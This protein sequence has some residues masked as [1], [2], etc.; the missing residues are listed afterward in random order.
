MQITAEWIWHK[1]TPCSELQVHYVK[2]SVNGWGFPGGSKCMSAL[3]TILF[4]LFLPLI[5]Q[6]IAQIVPYMPADTAPPPVVTPVCQAPPGGSCILAHIESPASYHPHPDP[7]GP[8]S[9]SGDRPHPSCRFELMM[10]IPRWGRCTC[11]S[12]SP[13]SHLFLWIQI[14]SAKAV[15]L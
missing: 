11:Q 2:K 4:F 10:P 13:S 6:H 5:K 14:L 3:S 9:I 1:H 15:L 8:D 12:R 7:A